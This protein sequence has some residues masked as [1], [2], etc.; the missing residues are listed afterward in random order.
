[1]TMGGDQDREIIA[2]EEGLEC[3]Y[4]HPITVLINPCPSPTLQSNPGV[5]YHP[6]SPPTFSSSPQLLLLPTTGNPDD[7]PPKLKLLH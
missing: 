5:S 1:M 6:R 4:H 2:H 7:D 3:R